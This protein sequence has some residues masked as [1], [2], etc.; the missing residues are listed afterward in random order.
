MTVADFS[1]VFVIL[2]SM[3]LGFNRGLFKE[4]FSLAAWIIAVLVAGFFSVPLAD[5]MTAVLDNASLRRLLASAILFIL[6]MVIGR[7]LGNFMS[8]LVRVVGLGW[9]DMVLGSL[10]GV[11]RGMIIIMLV[12]FLTKPFDFTQTW[13]KDSIFIPYMMIVLENVAILVN[14]DLTLPPVDQR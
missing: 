5:L 10:F 2:I 14:Y 12:L 9:I 8:K 6:V 11:I 4:A 13:Y 1:I 3:L 7:L